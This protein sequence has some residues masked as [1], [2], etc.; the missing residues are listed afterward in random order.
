MP[1]ARFQ[2]IISVFERYNIVHPSDSAKHVHSTYCINITYGPLNDGLTGSIFLTALNTNCPHH[3]TLLRT[4][5]K[6]EIRWDKFYLHHVSFY[7]S[8]RTEESRIDTFSSL[9][10]HVFIFVLTS[11]SELGYMPA[12]G[13]DTTR[14]K[15]NQAFNLKNKQHWITWSRSNIVL[16]LYFGLWDVPQ[17]RY[18]GNAPTLIADTSVACRPTYLLDWETWTAVI[19]TL[20]HPVS[21]VT[22][23][24]S[25][26]WLYGPLLGLGRFSVS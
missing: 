9:P 18:W 15:L 10:F 6:T 11:A 5:G 21:S 19:V 14:I 24:S 12:D 8:K 25:S 7:H 3:E 26:L 23:L 2:P 22:S 17:K 20:A 16:I 13:G 1:Q 4:V